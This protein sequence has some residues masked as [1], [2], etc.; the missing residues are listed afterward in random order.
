MLKIYSVYKTLLDADL[1]NCV[2]ARDPDD[3]RQNEGATEYRRRPRL[4]LEKEP[5]ETWAT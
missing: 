4:G 1:G 2:D 3:R 5:G